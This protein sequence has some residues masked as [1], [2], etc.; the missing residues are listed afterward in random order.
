MV[1][2]AKLNKKRAILIDICDRMTYNNPI[3]NLFLG[4]VEEKLGNEKEATV[5]RSKAMKFLAE[6]D[7]WKKQFS[8]L[9]LFNLVETS[10]DEQQ[11]QNAI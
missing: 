4:I 10:I 9:N 1:E 11:C 2:E 7:Y 8:A 6:S 5:C 3:A